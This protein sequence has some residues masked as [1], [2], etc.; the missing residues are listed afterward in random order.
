MKLLCNARIHTLD[1]SR[2]T[3]SA[4]AFE[5]GRI[6]AVGG[7]EL[8]A[9]FPRAE[10]EDM[11]G[12]VILPGLTD[13]H[14][15][16]MRYALALQQVDCE[17]ASKEE[18][19]RRVAA[20]VA[21]TR[22]GA[23]VCG[24]GWNQ[25]AWDGAWPTA[26]DLDRLAPHTPVFLTAKSL[27]AA[28]ANSEAL[29][30]AGVD[31]ATPDPP[32]GQFLRDEGGQP[33]GILLEEA[34]LQVQKAIPLPSL[35]EVVAALRAAQPLLWQMGLTGVHDFDP[36][37]S[38]Q[39]LQDLQGRGELSLRVVKSI[40][41]ENLS[42]ALEVG[43]RTGFGN[44][45][46]RI[47]PVK[48]FA[49]GALGPRTAAMLDPYV[50]EPQN[51]GI[52]NLTAEQIFEIGRRAAAGGLSL[53]VH[54]IG[55]RANRA[56]LDGLARLRQ[57]EQQNGLPAL[58]HRIEHVQV[59]HPDDASRLAELG[60]A[61]SMQPLHAPSDMLMAD[62]YLG[63]RTAW[64][65]GWQTQVRCGA[66]LAFGSDAPVESPNPFWGLHAAVTRRRLDGSPGPQ[67][68]HPEERVSL[69]TALEAF[70]S[71]PAY[72][73]GME[74]RLGRLAAGYLADLIVLDVDPFACPADELHLIHP[75]ATLVGGVWVWRS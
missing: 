21:E 74:D 61:A 1:P 26:A 64:S 41:L 32:H 42:A 70:S 22:P 7:E 12:R 51:C 20:R 59:I 36:L 54:A 33:T 43:L 58:R 23:W 49:D 6:V 25:N 62:R 9:E 66:R 60:V 15:H 75:V 11:G 27:H 63:E 35:E 28:W 69:Q 53:A 5:R 44:D 14:L 34:Y 16:L 38:F 50:D 45:F 57:Y 40:P 4:L 13:A 10:K 37:L 65:Y 47:G 68:W 55:D 71:G 30:L 67:G 39:A 19:L 52:L 48:V 17:T 73:A 46:L 56:V 8:P 24:H 2:P 3:A 72:L 31:A 18:C 29:R